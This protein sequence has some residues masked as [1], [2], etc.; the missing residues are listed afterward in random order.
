MT[1]VILMLQGS[2][3]GGRGGVFSNIGHTACA[4]AASECCLIF[5]FHSH[6]MMQ[7]QVACNE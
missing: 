3:A 7:K 5:Q 6:G 1:D 4:H 2:F